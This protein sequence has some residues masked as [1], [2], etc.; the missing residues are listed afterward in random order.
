MSN[1]RTT[2]AGPTAFPA[3]APASPASHESIRQNDWEAFQDVDFM[4]N[5]WGRNQAAA[6]DESYYWYLTF[7]DPR[8]SAIAE[9]CQETLDSRVRAP[10]RPNFRVRHGDHRPV[11]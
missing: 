5:H 2:L 11:E 4:E 8:L 7:D 10:A 3:A 1:S 9:S 6:D